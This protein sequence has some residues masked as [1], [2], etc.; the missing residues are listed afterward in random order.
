MKKVCIFALLALILLISACSNESTDSAS[1]NSQDQSSDNSEKEVTLQFWTA[2]DSFTPDGPG[3]QIIA[4]FNEK[5]K[6]KIKIETKYMPWD[7]Y[8]TAIQAAFAS[9]DLP[10]IYQLPSNLDIRQAVDKKMI[11]PLDDL[12]TE[13]WKSQ[14]MQ[15]SFAEGI[16]V[17]NGKTYSYPLRGPQMNSILYYNKDLLEKVGY[18]APPKD[19]AEFEDITQKVTEQG[20]GDV[21]GFI[22]GMATAKNPRFAIAGLSNVDTGTN[23]EDDW[24]FN[25]KTGQYDYDNPEILKA[26]DFMNQ[27]KKDNVILPASYTLKEPEAQALF[28]SGK[29]AFLISGRYSLWTIKRDYPELNL[30]LAVVPK[31]NGEQPYQHYTIATSNRTMVVANNAVHLEEIGKALTEAI[32]SKEYFSGSIQSGVSLAPIESLNKDESLYPWPEFKTFYELH[33]EYLK[34]RPDP[35]IGNPGTADVITELGGISQ[36]KITPDFTAILQMIL[37]GKTKDIEN[38]MK[39]YNDKMNKGLSDA[40]NK[41]KSNGVDV[42]LT[43]FAFQNWDASKDYTDAD[44]N[45]K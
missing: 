19:W 9:N 38:A 36:P 37:T 31:E 42:D 41:V 4:D 43:D 33:N 13:D 1:S 17:I 25:Y 2:S 15:G 45:S 5:N 40:I 35:S 22:M 30:G 8:N 24:G 21:Y 6:G 11:R 14:F 32:A 39:S 28:G 12:I 18:D 27:L 26:I 34:V 20:K 3:G 44:Y 7:Q 23:P 16:N 10:E 29:S